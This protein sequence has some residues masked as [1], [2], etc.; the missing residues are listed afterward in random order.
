M[1]NDDCISKM[2][3]VHAFDKETGEWVVSAS[4][5]KN[6]V[7]VFGDDFI[8]KTEEQLLEEEEGLKE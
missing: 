2:G 1:S 6:I 3:I 8:F 4:S 5:K 7:K